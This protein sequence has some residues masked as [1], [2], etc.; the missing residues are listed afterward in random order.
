MWRKYT[1]LLSTMT[2]PPP[3]T[4]LLI[5]DDLDIQ[6]VATMVLERMGGFSVTCRGSGRE[7]VRAAQA[8]PPDLILLDVMMP[9]MD[10]PDTLRALR[11]H[12]ALAQTPVVF[13]TAKAQPDELAEY[14]R[15]GALD[16]IIKPFDPTTLCDTVLDVWNRQPARDRP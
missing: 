9:E 8:A 15:L 13:M 6:T 16:V 4:I 12:P 11:R 2:V 3:K 1:R 10:G 5:E 14:R 7:G